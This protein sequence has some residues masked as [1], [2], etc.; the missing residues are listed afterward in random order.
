M[1]SPTFRP[2]LPAVG[3]RHTPRRGG[4]LGQRQAFSPLAHFSFPQ[5]PHHGAAD[6]PDPN[7]AAETSLPAARAG[8]RF[9][10]YA[11]PLPVPQVDHVAHA[12]VSV[13]DTR[14]LTRGDLRD[15]KT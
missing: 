14:R 7:E 11:L 4:N 12:I 8:A 13:A 6:I 1:I 10:V 3:K 2:V 15:C 9:S 5:P